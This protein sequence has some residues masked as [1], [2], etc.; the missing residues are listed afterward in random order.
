MRVR[1]WTGRRI[2][3]RRAAHYL[4]EGVYALADE[5][6]DE[7]AVNPVPWVKDV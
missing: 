3:R 7:E 1:I 5:A 6:K 2:S 4:C